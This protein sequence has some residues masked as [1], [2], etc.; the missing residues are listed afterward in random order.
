MNDRALNAG[1]GLDLQTIV[2]GMAHA[3]L[4]F[5]AEGTLRTYNKAAQQLF[6]ADFQHLRA[7]GWAAAAALFNSR[8]ERTIDELQAEALASARPVPFQ[9]IYRGERLPCR[10][11][12]LKDQFGEPFML[13]T[14]EQTDWSALR[15][16]LDRFVGETR[17][18]IMSTL[19]H[20]DLIR[21]SLDNAKPSDSP[22]KLNKRIGGFVRLIHIDMARS[23]R[24]LDL[25]ARLQS[26][27]LGTLRA[28]IEAGQRRMSLDSFLED[29]LEELD[30]TSFVDPDTDAQDFRSR[31]TLESAGSPV[32]FAAP[33]QLAAVLRDVIRNAIMYSMR[34]TP[35]SL[36]AVTDGDCVEIRIADV[37]YGIRASEIERVFQPFERARQPQIISE[38]G[39]GLSLYLCKHEVEAMNGRFWFESEV[40]VG[41]TFTV[42]LP[43]WDA[44]ADSRSSSSSSA[45]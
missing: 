6:D 10:A 5:D 19:G 39:Y 4:L 7:Q 18:A 25:M 13:I 28:Q 35:V 42:R 12:A 32:A 40:G 27:R 29:L 21:H 16:L 17:D 15:E 14:A 34:G 1:K 20:A 26:I 43:A 24:L 22:D 8:A 30:G 36:A 38:F 37:G 45:S 33:S 3:V 31:I 44:A 9:I 41:T 11:S 23:A 2:D